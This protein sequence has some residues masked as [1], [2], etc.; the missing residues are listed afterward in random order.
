MSQNQKWCFID[1]TIPDS[2]EISEAEIQTVLEEYKCKYKFMIEHTII[3]D[4]NEAPPLDK[5]HQLKDEFIKLVKMKTDYSEDEFDLEFY[6]SEEI[7]FEF[8]IKNSSLSE[9]EFL[10][11]LARI[12]DSEVQEYDTEYKL[13]KKIDYAERTYSKIPLI[14]NIRC[15][16]I[17]I[18]TLKTLNFGIAFIGYMNFSHS[19]K[20]SIKTFN[21]DM[22]K[23][24]ID[25]TSELFSDV[26]WEDN[27][28]W[29]WLLSRKISSGYR[30]NKK[31][32][33]KNILMQSFL[34]MSQ[35]KDIDGSI[36]RLLKDLL[37][38]GY[39]KEEQY[40]SISNM[41][42]ITRFLQKYNRVIKNHLTDTN[43]WVDASSGLIFTENDKSDPERV[44]ELNNVE[45]IY[46]PPQHLLHYV[47]AY[48][49]Q[50]YIEH[51]FNVVQEKISSSES[52]LKIIE[53]LTD[54]QFDFIRSGKP[55]KS[56]RDIDLLIRMKN[57][58][59]DQEYIV[60]VE[61]KR[62]AHEFSRVKRDI[63]TKISQRYA[64]IFTGFLAVAYFDNGRR[65]INQNEVMWG[66]EDNLIKKPCMLCVST[67]KET[68][69]Q[70]I[71][72]ALSRICT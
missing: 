11:Q 47:R 21:F 23:Y 30:E 38:K 34:K 31:H 70:Q 41:N 12:Q 56:S 55:T 48:W 71:I 60:A 46:A 50:D 1:L 22:L 57:V 51:I 19:M 13:L 33:S 54:L 15:E 42:N 35:S 59:N 65:S 5:I 49:H 7:I 67:D 29:K 27:I 37:D 36:S 69:E 6:E 40:L 39:L 62:N 3:F 66:H 10:S 68:L 8:N 24:L 63:A 53:L 58:K 44:S 4:I 18:F 45:N 28:N 43:I 52:E 61:A 9:E 32:L 25:K 64:N 16:N 20:V 72:D 17:A 2:I 14:H 26:E